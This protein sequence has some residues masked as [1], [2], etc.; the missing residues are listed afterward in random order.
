MGIKNAVYGLHLLASVLALSACGKGFDVAKKIE[1]A[2]SL[3]CPTPA[4]KLAKGDAELAP[5]V[6]AQDK[7]QVSESSALGLVATVDKACLRSSGWSL[8]SPAIQIEDASA[9]V[10]GAYDGLATVPVS[11]REGLSEAEVRQA[12]NEENCV[13][14]VSPNTVAY[15]QAIPND[16]RYAEQSHL[17]AI[18]H[19]VTHDFFT[20]VWALKSQNTVTIAIID[21]GINLTHEDLSPNLWVNAL[22]KNGV[23]G[24]DDDGNGYVDD[25]HGYDFSERSGDPSHKAGDFHGSHVAGLAAAKSNN[26]SGVSGVMT[27]SVKIMA[28]NVFGKGNGAT[29][30]AIDEAIRYAADTGAKVI[31]MSLGGSGESPSTLV[32]MQYAVSKGVV[33]VAAAGNSAAEITQANFVFPGGYAAQINGALAVAAFDASKTNELCA[34]SNTSATYVE[35]AAPG[36]DTSIASGGLLSAGT[37]NTY[38]LLRG[39]SMASPIVAGAVAA[40]QLAVLNRA[41]VVLTPALVETVLL[42]GSRVESGVAAKVKQGRVLSL[43]TLVATL[44]TTYPVTVSQCVASN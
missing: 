32:A 9:A 22:E 34:F 42:A 12:L 40:L 39:T 15:T 19:D 29:A 35:I 25:I 21:S 17:K 6:F 18:G 24:V 5:Q 31:N 30:A 8:K 43:P 13:I 44:E 41:N 33:I 10:S 7:L 38:S 11:I 27:G 23:T 1:S 14:G 26:T 20:S 36:C 3:I 28:L 37:G 16:T 4:A 2:E